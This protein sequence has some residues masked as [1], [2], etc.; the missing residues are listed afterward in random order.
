M[1]VVQPGGGEVI[2]DA[3]DRRG[4]VLA[5][6]A[7]V[8]PTPAR[9]GPRRGG[10][11]PHV[12][13]PPHHRFFAPE[14]GL[15]PPGRG[16]GARPLPR[17]PPDC[18]YVRGG[19]LTLRLGVDGREVALP[20]GTLARIPPLVVHGFRNGSPDEVRYLNL[21]APGESFA[22]YLRAMRD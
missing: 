14:G 2:G 13:P 19:E 11:D 12:H 6:H 18:F 1:A 17:P 15:P 21:H 5:H 9:F 7:G 10:A 16:G 4:G 20:A 22:D 8:N 3:P